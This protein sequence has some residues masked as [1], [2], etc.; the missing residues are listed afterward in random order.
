M[1]DIEKLS[2]LHGRLKEL[3]DSKTLVTFGSCNIAQETIDFIS[4]CDEVDALVL[5]CCDFDVV[6]LSP[7]FGGKISKI[8]FMHEIF[9]D[10]H[11]MQLLNIKSLRNMKVYDTLVSKKGLDRLSKMES[12]IEWH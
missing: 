3:S 6:D 2:E 5:Y 11:L 9:S 7:I 12:D 4:S 1:L 8:S 10:E